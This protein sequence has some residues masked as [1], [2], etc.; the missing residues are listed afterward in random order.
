[1]WKERFTGEGS[2]A[3]N[4]EKDEKDFMYTTGFIA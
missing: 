3:V 4:D 2:N 1:M